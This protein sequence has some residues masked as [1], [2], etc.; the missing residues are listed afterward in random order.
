MPYNVHKFARKSKVKE[1]YRNPLMSQLIEKENKSK[2]C[3]Y[4][5]LP[6][7]HCDN[8]SSVLKIILNAARNSQRQEPFGKYD[9]VFRTLI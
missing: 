9:F 2:Q 8:G 5:F 6:L 4:L 7:R 1:I 3:S